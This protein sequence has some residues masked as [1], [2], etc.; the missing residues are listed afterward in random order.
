MQVVKEKANAKINLF[1]DIT[2]VRDD[3]FHEIKTVMHSVSLFDSIYIS[4]EQSKNTE[5]T[6]T[7]SG[8][9]FLPCDEK[10]LAYKAA[11]LYLD[12]ADIKCK[13]KINIKKRIP[14]AAGLAGGSSD[15]AAVLRGMNK[16]FN[17]LFSVKALYNMAEKI[18][19]DVP[20]C[21]YGKTALCEGRGEVITKLT[22][23]LQLNVVVAIGK[24]RMSTAKAYSALDEMYPYLN[25]TK[26]SCEKV[27]YDKFISCLERNDLKNIELYNIFESVVFPKC[28]Q[29]EQIKSEMYELGALCAMMSGSGPSVFGVFENFEDAKNASKC[30]KE[31]NI[32]AFAAKSI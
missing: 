13:I 5:I 14:V 18:G 23:T 9:K 17:R 3:G 28:P 24:D 19:S 31:Q 27:K 6:L 1:L 32:Y 16:L 7:V 11:K 25:E 4:R 29:A 20:Y 2:G 10:N 8:N 22:D 21:L 12:T 15:A 30:L 26:G